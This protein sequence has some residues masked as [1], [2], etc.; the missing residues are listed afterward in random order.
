MNVIPFSPL[1]QPGRHR[2]SG[3][4]ARVC[5]TV[6][7]L[8]GV[9]AAPRI[10]AAAPAAATRRP[11]GDAGL[12]FWLENMMTHHGYSVEEVASATGL[13]P[14]EIEAARRVQ[15]GVKGPQ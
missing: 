8:I 7:L 6:A 1:G 13:P 11:R 15:A 9:M 10:A 4:I 2:I 14:D 5:V 12:R 3:W